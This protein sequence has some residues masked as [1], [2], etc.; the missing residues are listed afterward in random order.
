MPDTKEPSVENIQTNLKLSIASLY[1]SLN[2]S[3]T[4]TNTEDLAQFYAA[5]VE[6]LTITGLIQ[7]AVDDAA[8]RA[9]QP[10]TETMQGPLPRLNIRSS[11]PITMRSSAI[12]EK[13]E[14][15]IID[16]D[17]LV[18]AA[19]ALNIP[20]LLALGSTRMRA[21]YQ[22]HLFTT[23]AWSSVEV[24]AALSSWDKLTEVEQAAQLWEYYNPQAK[25]AAQN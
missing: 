11:A 13:A 1:A 8:I 10:V 16:E 17:P 3:S 21:L 20:E 9:G 2:G 15:V 18:T 14:P 4:I 7:D 6:L 23:E 25:F 5:S 24:D 19:Q 22:I 12:H